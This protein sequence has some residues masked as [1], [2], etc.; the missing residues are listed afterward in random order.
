VTE[1]MT[2][3]RDER[4]A[5]RMADREA[6]RADRRAERDEARK[7]QAAAE[8][9][10]R[11]DR[12]DRA[13]RRA[14]RLAAAKQLLLNETAT[15]FLVL[16]VAIAVSSAF[17]GQY[18]ALTRMGIGSLWAAMIGAA[19]ES[20]TWVVTIL[21]D[22]DAKAG[23]PTRGIRTAMWT[24]A[25][26]AA[27]FN[28]F[29]GLTGPHPQTGFAQAFLTPTAVFLWDA[30][31]RRRHGIKARTT[32]E[33]TRVR[34]RKAHA[35]KRAAEHKDV[36]RT[37]E[38]IVS[39]S[40]F[41]QVRFEEAFATA[42]EVHHGTREIG[43]TPAMVALRAQSKRRMADAL[44]L[45]AD[46]GPLFPDTVPVE[47]L[48]AFT[49]P[50][51]SVYRS[52]L[53]GRQDGDDENGG[54]VP[55]PPSGGPSKGPGGLERKGNRALPKIG[56]KTPRKPLEPAHIAQIRM[57]AE[58]LGGTDKLS[59]RKVREAIGGGSNEY[60]IRL[61]DAVRAETN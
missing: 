24:F 58:A 14:Q 3:W 4:R 36:K 31:Q 6:D 2:S 33:R 27:G 34:E 56:D 40:P 54:G 29:D 16:V 19:I 1:T 18:S 61:R 35:A 8:A 47:F 15:V 42:W 21:G 37:A 22:Q 53:D 5:D 30:R 10:R 41:E 57:L 50:V 17:H 20:A 25:A 46:A 52:P 28:L 12:A 38:R 48:D 49:G 45:D 51:G 7:D 9:R 23:R 60:A 26:I 55:L 43:L 59:A 32:E 44:G 13:A 11:K 39:A